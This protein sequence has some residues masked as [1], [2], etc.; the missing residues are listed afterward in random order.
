MLSE[1]PKSFSL[2]SSL[3]KYAFLAVLFTSMSCKAFS[4]FSSALTRDINQFN[5][6]PITAASLTFMSKSMSYPGLQ[7]KTQVSF[8]YFY[9]PEAV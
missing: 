9:N 5:F 1:T 4:Y 3:L 6:R 7:L 8:R 2:L